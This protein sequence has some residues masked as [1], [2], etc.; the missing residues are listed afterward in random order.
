PVSKAKLAT[1]ASASNGQQ[2]D[3]YF[4]ADDVFEGSSSLNLPSVIESNTITLVA[5]GELEDIVKPKEWELKLAE[6]E[7]RRREKKI[8]AL[9]K[10]KIAAFGA[11]S[12]IADASDSDSDEDQAAKTSSILS[13]PKG[14]GLLAMLPTPKGPGRKIDLGGSSSKGTGLMLPPSMRNKPSSSSAPTVVSFLAIFDKFCS[15]A[16]FLSF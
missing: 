11:L 7:K 3:S 1:S 4:A 13:K 16:I 6:K 15:D 14:S 5:E 9:G 2:Q 12:A 10:A 8:N